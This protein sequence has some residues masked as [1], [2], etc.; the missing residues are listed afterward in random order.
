MGTFNQMA[1][2]Q[3]QHAQRLIRGNALYRPGAALLFLH[4][5]FFVALLTAGN[6]YAERDLA[7]N[8]YHSAYLR[9]PA[10]TAM[11]DDLCPPQKRNE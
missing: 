4:S 6:V 9:F 11:T 1:A 7:L 5:I 2:Q 10:G 8:S 3:A